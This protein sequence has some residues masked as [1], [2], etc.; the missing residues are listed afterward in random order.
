[1]K[2]KTE[3]ISLP[4]LK[5]KDVRLF[6][7]RIDKVCENISGNK[8]Y[9]LKYNLIE[10]KKQEKE[11]LLT[12]GGSYSN[13]IA[14]TA[15]AAKKYGFKSI[16]IIRGEENNPLNPT[17]SFA[18]I[19]GMQIYY[20]DRKKYKK[21]YIPEYIEKLKIKFGEFYFIPEGGMNELAL[22]GCSEIIDENNTE[23]FICTSVGTGVTISG[24]INSKADNQTVIGFPAIKG[25]NKL[26]N[27]ISNWTHKNNWKLVN[28]YHFGGFAK[29]TNELIEF[30]IDFYKT[31]DIPLDAIYNGKM[32]MGIIDLIAND[33][34]PKRSKILAIHTGGIQ[35]NMGINKRFGFDLPII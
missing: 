5:L 26:L 32:M 17:L 2:I 27:D 10:A 8:W 13:H 23:D 18:K 19:N 1:M 24:L 6:V 28:T 31:Q 22:K 29:F 7:K 30:I 25:C 35:G 21:K 4:I 15:Y 34:F 33:Y 16:G 11:T 20:L 9:K 3:E 12:F 14:A